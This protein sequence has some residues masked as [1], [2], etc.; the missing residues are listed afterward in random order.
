LSDPAP[1]LDPL[2]ALILGVVQGLTE[3]IPVSSSAHLVLT[4]WLLGWEGS[5]LAF[6]VALQ[7]GTLLAVLAY[8]WRELWQIGWGSL[9]ALGGSREDR[10][11]LR[12]A[13]LLLLGSAPAA[14]VG[15]LL[16]DPIDRLFHSGERSEVSLA[17]IAAGLVVMGLALVWAERAGEKGKLSSALGPWQVLF[18]G[19]AQALALMPGVSRS[20]STITAGLLL[21]LQRAEAA[22]FSFLLS[23][24][25]TLGAG[26]LETPE[27]ASLRASEWPGFAVGVG[28]SAVVGYLSIAFL[29]HFLQTHS[30][31]IFALYRL[32]LALVVLA[33]LTLTGS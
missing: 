29:L 30:Y 8:F 9:R 28:A 33:V 1:A 16:E 31:R 13:G 10:P 22:R 17:A 18:I 2:H 15:F 24:P 14:L 19:A 7:L 25:I 3:F 6:N 32:A 27:L 21:G 26:L 23:V 11:S 12:L 5:G 4:P 20:G